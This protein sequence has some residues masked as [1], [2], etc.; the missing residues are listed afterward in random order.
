M[1]EF[2][3][4][5]SAPRM[6]VFR[7]PIRWNVTVV[8][9]FSVFGLPSMIKISHSQLR[10]AKSGRP[11][12]AP[13]HLHVV[14][15]IN[16]RHPLPQSLD[17]PPPFLSTL[18]TVSISTQ[19]VP[20]T[21]TRP[22]TFSRTVF[23]IPLLSSAIFFLP[24][25]SALSN[26]QV[27]TGATSGG[28]VTITWTQDSSDPS[29]CSFE[30]V[31]TVFHNSFAIANNIQTSLQTLSVTLPSVPPGYDSVLCCANPWANV[32]YSDGYTLEAVQIE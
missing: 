21:G 16:N 24:L 12:R 9:T 3:I 19:C 27:S 26:L 25:V 20:P 2:G 10:Q 18:T 1:N 7:K 15:G 17:S 22:S 31:N 6:R 30:L 5:Y 11:H 8:R 32:I 29:S 13:T 14:A 23:L 28:P 4:S